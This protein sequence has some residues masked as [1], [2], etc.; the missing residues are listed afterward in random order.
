M[1]KNIKNEAI[2]FKLIE[3]LN[4]SLEAIEVIYMNKINIP[5]RKIKNNEYENQKDLV[6]N[7]VK[8]AIEIVWIINKIPIDNGWFVIEKEKDEI[9]KKKNIK[10]CIISEQKIVYK[11]Y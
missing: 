8:R 3:N 7:P 5:P 6:N 10:F 11:K 2:I 4:I 1:K 9:I